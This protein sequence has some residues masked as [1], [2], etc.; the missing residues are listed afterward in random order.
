MK[1]EWTFCSCDTNASVHSK[2]EEQNWIFASVDLL[3]WHNL[4]NQRPWLS[5]F[6]PSSST[7]S[8]RNRTQL[9]HFIKIFSPA[10]IIFLW[11]VFPSSS[12]AKKL[13]SAQQWY[14]S[15]AEG[16]PTV[17]PKTIGDDWLSWVSCVAVTEFEVISFLSFF[18]L[19]EQTLAVITT[20]Q[21]ITAPTTNPKKNPII[22]ISIDEKGIFSVLTNWDAERLVCSLV[23]SRVA[24]TV[25]VEAVVIS[26]KIIKKR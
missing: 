3:A 11:F 12:R 23:F 18:L 20:S 4:C 26:V 8:S 21:V 2:V 16:T 22:T 14:E 6:F 19:L 5:F 15:A 9:L 13:S 7:G 17:W 24:V 25:D 10:F 1:E